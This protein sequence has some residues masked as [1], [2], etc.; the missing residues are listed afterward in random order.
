MS[1][2]TPFPL[3]PTQAPEAGAPSP[4]DEEVGG[5]RGATLLSGPGGEVEANPDIRRLLALT[6]EGLFISPGHR[7]DLGVLAYMERLRRTGRRFRVFDASI[8]EITRAYKTLGGGA[9]PATANSTAA[10]T[11][12]EQGKVIS[13]LKEAVEVDA[14]DLHILIGRDHC[15]IRF[16]EVGELVTKHGYTRQAGLTLASSLYGSMCDVAQGTFNQYASQRARLSASFTETLGLYG[17][18]VQ[19]RPTHDGVVMTLRLLKADERVMS[20]EELGFLQPQIEL[21]GEL[22]AASH[23]VSLISGPTGSGKSRTLQATMNKALMDENYGINAITVEDPPEYPIPGAVVTPLLVADRNDPSAVARAW[24]DSVSE[25]MRLDPDLIMVGEISDLGSAKTAISAA[26]TGHNVWSTLH[27]NDA[28]AIPKRLID[29]NV[30][31]ADVLDPTLMIGFTAQRLLPTLCPHCKI[32]LERGGRARLRPPVLARLLTQSHAAQLEQV[33]VRGDGCAHCDKRGI[34]GR[35]PVIEVVKTDLEFMEAFERGGALE[36][37][38]YWVQ[39]LDGV[40]MLRHAL[41]LVWQGLV[42]PRTAED[43][44]PLDYDHRMLGVNYANARPLV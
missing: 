37:R 24:Q 13:L 11:S 38:R 22:T 44:R 23:G 4:V 12:S 26:K 5:V 7:D 2:V 6:E 8:D 40:T 27:S 18:R 28:T 36:A 19:T 25:C 14:S 29:M 15:D 1:T 34:K 21:M 20:Y 33:H 3:T 9:S 35:R 32:P 43:V 31:A 39:K 16:R 41:H 42:D 17:A 10:S 30:D